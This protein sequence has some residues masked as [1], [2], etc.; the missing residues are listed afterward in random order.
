V[1]SNWYTDIGATD[2]VT[3]ELEK[4]TVR[5]KYKGNDQVHTASGVGIDISHIG[6]SIVK[7][8]H[9]NIMLRNVL[10]VPEANKNLVFVHKLASDN[11][12]FLEYHPNYF[13]I[14]GHAT[15]KPLL[16]GRCHK[17]LYP[18]QVESLK[19]AFGAFK[20]SL[21][22][23]HSHLGHPSIPIIERIVSH[24]NLP[25]SS[26]SNKESVCDACQ[27]A[28]S[29][30]L[31]YSKSN[32]S[33]SHPLELIYSDVWGH[34]P[35]SVGN[36]QYYIRFI[37]DYSKFTWIYPLKFK[38]DVFS[39]FVEFQKLVERHYRP[40]GVGRRIPEAPWILL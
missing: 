29:H 40:N 17:G 35:K 12:A 2:H 39:K 38:S 30:Q 33:S 23:W 7:T 37:D 31:P 4:L 6:H 11:S 3:G 14:K 10:Y 21:A 20:P 13:V 22:R 32:S 9:R 15:R 28:K 25:C 24:F 5:D 26:E 34:A 36:K 8:P 1:D 19:L 27:R 16:K 18:L